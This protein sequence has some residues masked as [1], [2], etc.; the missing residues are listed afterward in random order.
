MFDG[1]GRGG[2]ANESVHRCSLFT[3]DLTEEDPT[4]FL[5]AWWLEWAKYPRLE[6]QQRRES[7]KE[8]YNRGLLESLISS[9]YGKMSAPY[10]INIQVES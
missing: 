3:V 6:R 2:S 7:S 5:R 1:D 10:A 8:S 4:N 9:P